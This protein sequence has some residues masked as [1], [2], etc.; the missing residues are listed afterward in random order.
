MR[1]GGEGDIESRAFSTVDHKLVSLFNV[2]HRK[3]L[4][5]NL[6]PQFQI[7][8]MVNNLKDVWSLSLFLVT[9]CALSVPYPVITPQ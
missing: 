9:I 3:L 4:I 5:P 7:Y 6:I 1:F 2:D 8:F